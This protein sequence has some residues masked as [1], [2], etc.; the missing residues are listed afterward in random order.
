VSHDWKFETVSAYI[1]VMVIDGKGFK[2]D[3]Q[4]AGATVEAQMAV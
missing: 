2:L 3:G 4:K 1:R